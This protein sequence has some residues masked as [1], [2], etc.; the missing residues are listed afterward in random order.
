MQIGISPGNGETFLTSNSTCKAICITFGKTHPFSRGNAIFQILNL[1]RLKE[2]V[3]FVKVKKEK[4]FGKW[5][6]S[7]LGR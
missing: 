1:L 5:I 4:N 3:R 2:P 6:N 7:Y